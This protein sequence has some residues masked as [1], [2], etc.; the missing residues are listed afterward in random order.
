M[1]DPFTPVSTRCSALQRPPAAPDAPASTTAN[2]MTMLSSNP[3]CGLLLKK[4]TS[5]ASAPAS[6]APTVSAAR[7]VSSV[8]F[9]S[10]RATGVAPSATVA[11]GLSAARSWTNRGGSRRTEKPG[12]T[13]PLLLYTALLSYTMAV[14]TLSPPVSAPPAEDVTTSAR[15]TV[16][17]FSFEL[18][19][20]SS[21]SETGV[22]AFAFSFLRLVYGPRRMRPA[23]S[24]PPADPLRFSL[25]D[26]NCTGSE[27]SIPKYH[28]NQV[29]MPVLTATVASTAGA[30]QLS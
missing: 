8:R 28:P 27:T 17:T 25:P 12:V 15:S 21:S 1:K 10:L 23:R 2:P 14:L 30:S 13:V 9:R 20:D 29:Q 16:V 3:V 24:T 7:R 19:K 18:E 26:W 22:L 11:A 6:P 4:F 5:A